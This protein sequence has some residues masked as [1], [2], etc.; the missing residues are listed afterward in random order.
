MIQ[1]PSSAPYLP[2]LTSLF[3]IAQEKKKKKEDASKK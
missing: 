1:F 3:S 2:V